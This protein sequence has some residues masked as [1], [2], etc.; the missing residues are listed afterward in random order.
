MFPSFIGALSV[1][2]GLDNLIDACRLYNSN[3]LVAMALPAPALTIPPEVT[4]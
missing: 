4:V 3:V 2:Y 1:H